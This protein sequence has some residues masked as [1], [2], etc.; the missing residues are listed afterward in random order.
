MMGSPRLTE[1]H[2][3]NRFGMMNDSSLVPKKGLLEV[4]TQEMQLRNYSPKTIKSY[5]SCIRGLINFS[6]PRHPRELKNEDIRGY[7][8]YLI[9]HEHVAA[10]TVNQVFNALRFLY[11]EL[12]KKPF[13]VDSIPRPRKEKKLP[14]VLSQE[15]V[16]RIFSQVDNLKHKTMLM[17]IYSAGLRVGE[18]VRLKVSDIDGLRKM[19][20]LR[21]AKG[22]KDRYTLLSDTALETLREYYKQYKPQDFLFAGAEGRS[23]LSERSIQHVFERARE[24]AGIYKPISIH[25]LRHSFATH[26]LE[27]GVDLRYIQEI[28]GHNSSKT[29]EIYTHVSKKTLGKII[30]PLDVALQ[31]TKTK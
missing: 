23:H 4:L 28:L 22:K 21:N 3:Q 24:A 26:L 7:L 14:T 17:L 20:H 13:T 10:S 30:N 27:S 6:S 11:V 18:S 1:V 16:L 5:K 8:L 12:Y 9:E 19:I 25:G 2:F 29:T 31:Q 15:E